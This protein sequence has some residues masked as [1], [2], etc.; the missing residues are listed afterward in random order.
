MTLSDIATAQLWESFRAGGGAGLV[1][2]AVEFA[3]GGD[4]G[5]SGRGDRRGAL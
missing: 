3:P 2:E 5:R 1:R 4:R